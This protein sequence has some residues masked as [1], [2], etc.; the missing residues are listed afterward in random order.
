MKYIVILV[1]ITV[2]MHSATLAQQADSAA[3]N[4]EKTNASEQSFWKKHNVNFAAM[5]MIN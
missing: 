3:T 4:S 2:F 1:L 5:P